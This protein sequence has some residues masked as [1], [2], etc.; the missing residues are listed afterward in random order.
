MPASTF[1]PASLTMRVRTWPATHTPSSCPI[2]ATNSTQ[3]IAT[4]ICARPSA[5]REPSG[6]ASWAPMIA[7]PKK[8]I[9]EN[10]PTTAPLRKPPM[11]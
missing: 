6:S 9:I 8:P 4:G 11:P 5:R 1:C 7:P 10:S 3:T 2:I